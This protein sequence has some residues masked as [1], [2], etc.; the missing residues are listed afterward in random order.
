MAQSVPSFSGGLLPAI[1]IT[2]PSISP[3]RFLL[4]ILLPLLLL[5]GGTGGYRLIEGWSLLDS[6]YMTVITLTTV[7]Y[8]EVG[9]LS[10]GGKVFTMLLSM[11]GVFTIFY[12]GTNVIAAIVGGEVLGF[13]ESRRMEKSLS[14]LN[15]H[16]IVCGYGRMGRLVCQ[17]FSSQG[18]PFVVLDRQEKVFE[19]FRLPHGL[20]LH[21]D[22]TLDETL[23][24]AGVG[25]ARALVTVVP[26]DADNLYIT[27][28][29]RL[30]NDR[31][32]IVA[33]AEDERSEQKL[34]RAGASRVVSP[35]VI[36][37][38]RVAQAVLRPNVVDFLE[39]ATRTEH[40]E[41]NIE[42]TRLAEGS[43]LVGNTLDTCRLRHDH[44]LIVVAIKKGG[45]KMVFN[46]PDEM[47]LAAGDTLIMLG[48]REDLDR[49]GRL[50]AG[51]GSTPSHPGG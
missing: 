16:L 51:K 47:A 36:G 20:P 5:A 22:A 15:G 23:Q 27:M 33:R 4:I 14:E 39:L 3:R 50:A 13:L 43:S 31:M 41:L 2:S 28:S 8:R 45:G 44:R 37:G 9:E 34:L 7:G 25:R 26:S 6:I 29:A 30:L 11:G 48:R 49:V 1:V 10:T 24:R 38:A 32:F 19:R 35:Y 42:E 12:A 17:E 46:P 21:G 18:L 40:L